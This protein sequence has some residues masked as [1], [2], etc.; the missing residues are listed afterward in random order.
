MEERKNVTVHVSGEGPGPGGGDA[1]GRS[2]ETGVEVYWI[3][4]AV[5]ATTV[6]LVVILLYV[7][8]RRRGEG[9]DEHEAALRTEPVPLAAPA[10]TLP[11][12]EGA[13]T[14]LGSGSGADAA[15]PLLAA[16]GAAAVGVE[17]ADGIGGGT[18]A[19]PK[20]LA[21]PVAQAIRDV[22]TPPPSSENQDV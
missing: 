6:V 3:L 1:G 20:P 17:E 5:L 13:V 8:R 10:P 2:G 18:V 14:T 7:R 21:L 9:R 4:M 15:T 16:G 11:P 19:E 12:A 22:P